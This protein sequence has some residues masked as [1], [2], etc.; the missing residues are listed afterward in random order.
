MTDGR[1]FDGYNIRR[2]A[3]GLMS[4]DVVIPGARDVRGTLDSPGERSCVVACP[5]HPDHGGHR[6]DPRLRAVSSALGDAGIACLRFDYG[7]WDGGESVVTDADQAVTWANTQY[8]DVAVFGYSFGGAV[9]L[10][11]A[12]ELALAGVSVLAPAASLSTDL[13]A[14]AAVDD[15]TMPLQVVVGT[16]DSTV[17]WEA[18]VTSA[19]RQGHTIIEHPADHFFVGQY[20]RIADEIAPF[21]ATQLQS[22]TDG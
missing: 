8:R 19:R 17:N 22:S 14:A 2:V 16:R 21:L 20:D 7:T 18:V 5:P 15:L 4:E 13:D 11:A 12:S 1:K 3:A 9:A 10:L 6:G